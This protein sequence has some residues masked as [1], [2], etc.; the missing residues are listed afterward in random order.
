MSELNRT[1]VVWFRNDLRLHD[2]EPLIS[3][4]QSRPANLVCVY[5]LDPRHFGTTR[6]FHFPKT[7]P[8]RAKF[9]FES[10]ADL[11]KK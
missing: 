2:H 9:L 5:V 4:L 8:I 3:A 10:L 6:L 1:A 7:G 11:R